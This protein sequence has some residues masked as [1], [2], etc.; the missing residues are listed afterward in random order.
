[1]MKYKKTKKLKNNKSSGLDQIINEYIKNCPKPV[2]MLIVKLFNIIFKSGVVPSEWCKGL[3][4]PLYKNKGSSKCVD[5]YRGITLLSCLGKLFTSVLNSRLEKFVIK[6][7]VIGE[8]QAGFRPGYCT[9]DHI[10]VLNSLIQLYKARYEQLYCVFIDYKKA[11]DL[12]VRSFLWMKLI[13]NEINGNFVKVIY[14]LY[15]HAKSCVKKGNDISDFFLCNIG[16]RQGENLSPLLFSI[17]L[18]DFARHVGTKYN[19]LPN[20]SRLCSNLMSDDD[21]E[22]FVR[23]FVLLY[24]DDTIVLAESE[25]ELQDALIGVY[26]YC[27]QWQLKVNVDKT[28]IVIFSRGKIRKHRNFFFGALPIDVVDEYTYLGM[29]CNYDG[30]FNKAIQKQIKQANKAM[31]SL[32]TKARRLFLP[33]DI[34]FDTFEKTVVPV[35]TYACEIWGCGNL[36]PIEIFY[37]KF[38]KIILNLNRSTPSAIV[39]GEVGKLPLKNIIYKRMISFWIK[40]SEDKSTKYSTIIYNLLYKLHTSG[41]YTFVWLNKIKHLLDSCH[42]SNLWIDQKEY[43]TKKHLKKSIFEALDHLEQQK[44]LNEINTNNLCLSYRIFK[45]ELNFEPYLIKLPF[46][47]RINL[48][49]FRCK[50]N[51]LP[52]NE[53]RFEKTNVNKNCQL[54]NS[55]DLGDEFHYLFIC[56][57]FKDERKL[58]LNEYYYKRPNT[59]KMN[60]LFNICHLK[61][62]INLSK[63]VKMI[64][65]KFK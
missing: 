46:V 19:G 56:N 33:I 57:I 25:Q 38:I 8:E 29:V 43:S 4:N 20:V 64:L 5:N 40:I 61:T 42:F 34:I 3:I 18:N 63:F 35:L 62:Q 28:K 31:Y 15:H 32:L 7:G 14:N 49:K 59:M 37:K 12:V 26:E 10:F 55:D 50:N 2:I 22:V 45:Q 16:V 44:W 51:K 27:D 24:A 58:L 23:L 60:E 48:S 65:D 36:I 53:F 47:H 52:V 41:A 39:Y 54:C 11:F 13:E 21:I 6:R 1:M 17:F 9:Q 30:T